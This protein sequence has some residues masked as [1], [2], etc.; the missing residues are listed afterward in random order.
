MY[1]VYDNAIEATS[2]IN[3]KSLRS[4]AIA[5]DCDLKATELDTIYIFPASFVSR[6][7][8]LLLATS[9]YK[10]EELPTPR[11]YATIDNQ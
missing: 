9:R 6:L 7:K 10:S 4:Y 5:V 1:S 3:A 2:S 11:S 8:C